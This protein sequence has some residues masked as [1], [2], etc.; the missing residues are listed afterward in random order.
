MLTQVEINHLT[1]GPI[2][3]NFRVCVEFT[4]KRLAEKIQARVAL[5]ISSLAESRYE[6]RAKRE[7]GPR[8]QKEKSSPGQLFVLL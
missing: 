6:N 5:A 4:E 7:N 1:I 3:V 8:D 2:R